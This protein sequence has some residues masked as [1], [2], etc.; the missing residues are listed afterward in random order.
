MPRESAT[1]GTFF[2]DFLFQFVVDVKDLLKAN[3]VTDSLV[4][5][6]FNQ[7][8]ILECNASKEPE[9]AVFIANFKVRAVCSGIQVSSDAAGKS[10]KSTAHNES[11]LFGNS[12]FMIDTGKRDSAD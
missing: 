12:K 4:F 11:K 5:T 8:A 1:G 9:A 10:G 6:K 2:E 7:S 3:L